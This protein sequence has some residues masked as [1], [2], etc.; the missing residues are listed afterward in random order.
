MKKTVFAVAITIFFHS[1]TLLAQGDSPPVEI[2]DKSAA[3]ELFKIQIDKIQIDTAG[4][5]KAT[6][7]LSGNIKQVSNSNDNLSKSQAS[8][9]SEDREAIVTAA[10]S[11]DATIQAM[12]KLA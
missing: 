3:P 12:S 9:R 4:L 6:D 10:L 1:A 5:V 2:E 8:L 11:V 7:I